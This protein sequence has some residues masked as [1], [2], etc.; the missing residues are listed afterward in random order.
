MNLIGVLI[1]LGREHE[2]Q[3]NLVT[4]IDD[5]RPV[6]RRH[7]PDMEGLEQGNWLQ[8]LVGPGDEVIDGIRIG[9]IGPENDDVREQEGGLGKRDAVR[10]AIRK[11]MAF[12]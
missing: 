5:I 11:G 8:I 1:G 2:V 9:G 3:G 10:F 7:S 12:G 6:A 4:L